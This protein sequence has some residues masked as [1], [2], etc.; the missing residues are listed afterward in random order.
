L[1]TEL[2]FVRIEF[3]TRRL[4]RLFQSLALP[5]RIHVDI[6][7]ETA[8]HA[9]SYVRVDTSQDSCRARIIIDDSVLYGTVI[10]ASVLLGGPSV[11]HH[12]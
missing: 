9:V 1:S 4:A 3:R 7:V 5:K 8:M 10:E 11:D 6:P 12:A 2:R